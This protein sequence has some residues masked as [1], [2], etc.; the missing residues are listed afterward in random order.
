MSLT[1]HSRAGAQARGAGR[2]RYD[3]RQ[4][5][6]G[7]VAHDLNLPALRLWVERHLGLAVALAQPSATSGIIDGMFADDA[8]G[9]WARF[10]GAA[11][12]LSSHRDHNG[13]RDRGPAAAFAAT[14]DF[15]QMAEG[16]GYA[17][18]PASE[19]GK[20]FE[21][22]IDELSLPRPNPDP[23]LHQTRRPL[24]SARPNHQKHSS[25]GSN[26]PPVA[27]ALAK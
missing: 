21:A 17:R 7:K 22:A 12:Q 10:A 27:E 2:R 24:Y 23:A 20:N 9:C 18:P 14:G 13:S 6:R 1:P 8:T 25:P 26:V 3:D 19:M 16:A 15:A 11:R 4:R 5:R